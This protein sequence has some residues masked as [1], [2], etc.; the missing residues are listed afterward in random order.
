MHFIANYWDVFSTIDKNGI[1]DKIIK[2]L[3]LKG[4]IPAIIIITAQQ[5]QYLKNKEKI[6]FELGQAT[7]QMFLK[8]KQFKLKTKLIYNIDAEKI[9]K[10][11]NLEEEQPLI[12]LLIGH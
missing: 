3:E 1:K 7:A 2:S 12:C 6:Y 5:Q 4:N 9:S 8:L 11:L 10:N